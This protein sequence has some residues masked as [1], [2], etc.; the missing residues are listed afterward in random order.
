MCTGLNWLRK[1]STA[2]LVIPAS[3]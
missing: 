2:G 3:L 1:G